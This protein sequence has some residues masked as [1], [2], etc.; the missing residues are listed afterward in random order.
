MSNHQVRKLPEQKPCKCRG[1]YC[2]ATNEN[3]RVTKPC[4]VYHKANK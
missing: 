2:Y 1:G 4:I 3:G